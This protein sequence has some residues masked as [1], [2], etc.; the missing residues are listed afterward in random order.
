MPLFCKACSAGAPG[1]SVPRLSSLFLLLVVLS[2]LVLAVMAVLVSS[3]ASERFSLLKRG[4]PQHVA[5]QREAL[6]GAFRLLRDGH[7][8]EARAIY[9]MVAREGN[10]DGAAG[11]GDTY[12]PLILAAFELPPE[13]ADR[14][15]ATFWYARFREKPKRQTPAPTPKLFE[16]VD[17]SRQGSK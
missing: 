7:V 15:R 3:G 4:V 12:N 1:G 6:H 11:V 14:S 5:R 16:D 17:P 8:E 2:V 9:E 13:R 10:P